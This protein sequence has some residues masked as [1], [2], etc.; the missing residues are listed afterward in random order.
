MTLR[1]ADNDDLLAADF[2]AGDHKIPIAGDGVADKKMSIGEM[3]EIIRQT[4]GIATNDVFNEIPTGTVNGAND[5]FTLA[6]TPT[7]AGILL[8][9]SGL[10]MTPGGGNDYTLSGNTITFTTPPETGENL[11]ATYKYV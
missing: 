1:L 11:L 8:F 10:C 3:A 6:N 7:A 4:L 5:T 9:R 2:D